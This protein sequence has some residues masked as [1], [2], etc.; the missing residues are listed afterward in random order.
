MFGYPKD[1]VE[2]FVSEINKAV[3]EKD[4]TRL[5]SIDELTSTKLVANT[6][7]LLE[8]NSRDFLSKDESISQLKAEIETLQKDLKR[9]KNRNKLILE[10][11]HEGLWYMYC[12]EHKEIKDDTPFVW[13]DKFRRM[14]GF[15]DENDFPNILSSWGSR[16]HP[17]DAKKTFDMFAAALA[18]K[19]GNTKYNPTYRLKTRSGEYRWFKTDGVIQRD[20]FGNPLVIVGSLS[21]MH[22]AI[23]NKKAFTETSERF[24]LSQDIIVDGIWDIQLKDHDL[25]SPENIYWFSKQTKILIGEDPD[26]NLP[27]STSVF[28]D[29]M[30]KEDAQNVTQTL[31]EYVMGPAR[32]EPYYMEFQMKPKGKKDYQWFR[33]VAMCQRDEKGRPTRVVATFSNI[34][35]QKRAEKIRELE[36]EQTERINKNLNDIGKI[37]ETIDEISDQTNL[38]ALNAAIE[39]ARAGEHGRGF[40]VVAD[41][42]RSLAERTQDAINEI[43]VMLKTNK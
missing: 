7:K 41:E 2:R 35:A 5:N 23:A 42:V 20:E 25:A 17:E 22:D 1:K 31:G 4:A 13:S 32:N 21:D 12:S 3:S 14:I 10:S 29:K 24:N 30:P 26:A 27:N 18:D 37:V 28:M 34:D 11:S 15:N 19:T 40:A 9:E 33:G 6:K 38:L 8:E 36:K 43:S 39:A 16:L